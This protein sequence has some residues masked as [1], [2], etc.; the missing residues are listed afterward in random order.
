MVLSQ[1]HKEPTKLAILPIVV[2]TLYLSKECCLREVV[3]KE[4]T[5]LNLKGLF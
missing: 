1:V 4:K 5:I 2:E 3:G